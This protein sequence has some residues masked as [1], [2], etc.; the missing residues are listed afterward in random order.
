MDFEPCFK[1]L[2]LVVLQLNSAKLGQISN[3]NIIFYMVVSIYKLDKITN[4]IQSPAQ[5]Q[6]GLQNPI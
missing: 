5:P 4:W 6:R 3:L 2:N 1:V